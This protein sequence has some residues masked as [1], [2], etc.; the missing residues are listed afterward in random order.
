MM[1]DV[2]ITRFRATAIRCR[3]LDELRT[4]HADIMDPHSARMA[5]KT[6]R[7]APMMCT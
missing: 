4:D 2:S 5:R 3:P 6:C 7:Q 1:R